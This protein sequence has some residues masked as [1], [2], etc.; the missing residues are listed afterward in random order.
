MNQT[1]PFSIGTIKVRNPV[2][3]APMSGITD[4]PFRNLA[5]KFGAGMVVSEMVASEALSVGNLEMHRKSQSGEC[6]THVVQ[7][8]GRQEYWMGEGARIA[9][10]AGADIIDINMGCPSKRVT[11]GYS[12]SALMRDLGLARRLIEATVKAA[13][14]PVT[15]KMRL[16]WDHSTINAPE[17]ARCAQDAG[18]QMITV[19]GRTRCQFY[20]GRADWDLVKRVRD[21]TDLPLVVNGDIGNLDDARQ[22]QE[23]SGADAVMVGRAA[24]GAPWLPGLIAS[25]MA[26][27]SEIREP[28]GRELMSIVLEH[29]H[30]ILD[31]YGENTGI[32]QARKHLGWYFEWLDWSQIDASL[33]KQALTSNNPDDVVKIIR[34]VFDHPQS[35][36]AA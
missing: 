5:W 10:N 17:L 4:V 8:S 32:R 2:F 18:I 3:L 29:Y 14:V 24:Y 13:S 25:Q 22:A 36:R 20:K 12:G 30:A 34:S 1:S 21:A 16:G 33:R 23:K 7:L 31:F 15:L 6:P 11:T 35:V 26:G 19:H 28:V 9:E 27:I